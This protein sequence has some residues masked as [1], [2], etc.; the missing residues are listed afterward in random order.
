MNF[1]KINFLAHF[2]IYIIFKPAYL[3]EI[4]YEV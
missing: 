1:V 2:I 4:S 3:P